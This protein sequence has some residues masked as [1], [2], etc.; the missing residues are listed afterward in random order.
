MV[1]Y[2]LLCCLVGCAVPDIRAYDNRYFGILQNACYPQAQNVWISVWN[3]R[4]ELPLPYRRHL[5][6]TVSLDG[7][8]VGAGTWEDASG[9][10]VHGTVK[11]HISGKFF[12]YALNAEVAYGDCRFCLSLA[13]KQER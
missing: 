12:G 9:K 5:T 6:G 7:D 10:D 11:G 4:F 3:G 1:K 13:P 8:L 2:L